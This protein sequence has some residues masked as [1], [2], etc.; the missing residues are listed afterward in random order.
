MAQ[1]LARD[2]APLRI[3]V[4]SPGLVD[5]PAY[6]G[7]PAEARAAMFAGAAKSLPVG[8][9]GHSDDIAAAV[10]LLIANTFATGVLLDLDGG[11]RMPL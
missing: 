5:T 9:V 11:A 1:T 7:M 6:A 3:N 8:R 4:V 2:L 10:E